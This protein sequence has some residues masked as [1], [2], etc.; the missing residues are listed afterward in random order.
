[1][2]VSV[3]LPKPLEL[4]VVSSGA[5]GPPGVSDVP[6]PAGPPGPQGDPGEPSSVPGPEGPAGPPGADSTVPGPTGPAGP[7]G[8]ASTVPGPTGPTGSQGIPGTAGATG[9]AGSPGPAGPTAVSANTPNMAELGSDS[10]LFVEDAPLT[11]GTGPWARRNGSWVE[12]EIGLIGFFDY[13]FNPNVYVAPPLSGNIR[14][15]NANQTLATKVWLH[16]M[17]A[18]NNDA[19]N[20]LSSAIIAGDK[21]VIQDKDESTRWQRY[22][23]S[24]NVDQGT[25]HELTVTWEAGGTAL[26]Q[27]RIGVFVQVQRAPFT[28]DAPSDSLDYVRNNGAWVALNWTTL[29]GKPTTTTSTSAPSGGVDGDVWYQVAS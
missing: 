1:M 8:A 17:T 27:Q 9:A 25:Y 26:V 20:I 10:L 3:V 5:Q 18:V 2:N 6:G 15:N 7:A 4:A 23:V 13:T 21:I 24:A 29:D 16:D 28:Q 22:L 14:M 19:S 11:T 12:I